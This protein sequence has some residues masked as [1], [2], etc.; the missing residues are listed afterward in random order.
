MLITK[1]LCIIIFINSCAAESYPE[2]NYDS[3]ENHESDE[4]YGSKENHESHEN[5]GSKENHESEES[6]ES[7]ENRESGE[8]HENK[9]N[10]EDPRYRHPHRM[11]YLILCTVRVRPVPIFTGLLV[12]VD[13]RF[14][15]GSKSLEHTYLRSE[16]LV[17]QWG[18]L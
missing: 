15:S 12:N 9:E 8:N 13:A 5:Y 7:E 4:I 10:H 1:F 16:S 17:L 3:E 14:L 18:F 11:Y 2:E 6:H